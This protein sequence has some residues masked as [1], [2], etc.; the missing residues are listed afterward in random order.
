[1][2]APSRHWAELGEV[3]FVAGIRV[4][5]AVRRRCGLWPFRLLLWPVVLF[6]W[7]VHGSAR[8]ASRD[9]LQRWSTH[10]GRPAPGS[11]RHFLRFADVLA[12]KLAAVGG[13]YPLARVRN[14]GLQHARRCFAEGK[15]AVLITAHVGCLELC[16]AAAEQVPELR[17]TVLVHTHHAEAFNH[18]LAELRPDSRLRLL[19]VTEVGP[20]TAMDLADRVARGEFVAI[21]GDRVPVGGGRVVEASFLGA[22][23]AFPVGPWVLAGLL[24]CP[25]MLLSCI[26]DGSGYRLRLT[27]FAERLQ[28][29]RG[30][31]QAVLQAWVEQYV[32]W[33]QQ[34]VAE[35]PLEWFNFF[36]FWSQRVESARHS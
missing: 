16:Q 9:Y 20:A 5:L 18:L 15:G 29:P 6:Y 36:D 7:L 4:L 13:G 21:V 33:L 10:F 14:E 11:L 8:R 30:Q 34:L 24:G 35:R 1:M 27:P 22:P 25:V 17:I 3:T 31:R 32:Q 2:S 28:L 23:A 19:Q 26:G 12:D